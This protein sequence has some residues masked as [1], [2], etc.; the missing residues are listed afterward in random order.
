LS[1]LAPDKKKIDIIKPMSLI[2][3]NIF[4]NTEERKKSKKLPGFVPGGQSTQ[5]IIGASPDTDFK[6]MKLASNLYNTFKLKRV[7]YSAYVPVSTNDSRLPVIAKPPLKRE[8]RLYQADWLLR[9]YKFKVDEIIDQENPDF[10]E[11]FDPKACWAI[12]NLHLFPVEINK[13]DYHTLLRVPG[14]GVRS[15]LK[16]VSS[17]R[18]A[19]LRFEDLKKMGIVLKR[20]R[21]FITCCGKF[22]KHEK[23]LNE[24]VIKK[25]LLEYSKEGDYGQLYLF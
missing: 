23:V 25:K 8:N 17:R 6:I 14:I 10:D 3:H 9:V 12:R 19:N 11:N 7:Y 18:Y 16:I 4:E 22:F 24:S 5:L 20:A 13:A 15:A 2:G 21:F 1:K